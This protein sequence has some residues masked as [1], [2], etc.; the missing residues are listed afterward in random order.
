MKPTKTLEGKIYKKMT[1]NS[2]NTY[3]G[4]LNKLVDEYNNTSHHSIDK[5]PVDANFSSLSKEAEPSYQVPKFK[6][7]EIVRINN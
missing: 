7:G 4:Y 1:I 3:L 6:L 5:K 2:S